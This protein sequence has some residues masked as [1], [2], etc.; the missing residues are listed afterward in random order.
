MYNREAIINE[1]IKDG[2]LMHKA[3]Y[4]TILYYLREREADNKSLRRIVITNMETWFIF[5]ALD[6]NRIF[7]NSVLLKKYRDYAKKT[8]IRRQHFCFL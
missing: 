8:S 3:F 4:E 1:M 5:D 2:D 6:F 7:Y